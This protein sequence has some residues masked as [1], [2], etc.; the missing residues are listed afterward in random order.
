MI[1]TITRRRRTELIGL[2]PSRDSSAMSWSASSRSR[3]TKRFMIRARSLGRI[4]AQGTAAQLK[5]ALGLAS[6]DEVFLALTADPAA[7]AGYTPEV[8]R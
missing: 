8:T 1:N 3:V 5:S 7:G 6:L 2:P 4:V